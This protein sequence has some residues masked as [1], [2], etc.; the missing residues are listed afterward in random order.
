MQSASVAVSGG[1]G[2]REGSLAQPKHG[3]KAIHGLTALGMAEQVYL[4]VQQGYRHGTSLS[5]V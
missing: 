1:V 4:V 3:E 5:R 2:P